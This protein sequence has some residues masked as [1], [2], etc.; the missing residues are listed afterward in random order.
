MFGRD[1]PPVPLPF[2]SPV[3]AMNPSMTRWNFSPVI[4]A[5]LDEGLELGHV[6]RR[7]I[8]AQLDGDAAILGVEIDR[9]VVGGPCHGREPDHGGEGQGQEGGP[10]MEGPMSHEGAVS[11]PLK[12]GDGRDQACVKRAA[13]RSATRGGTKG[14]TSPPMAAIWRTRVAV[15]G[16][17]P[18][19]AGRNTVCTSGAMAPFMPASCIS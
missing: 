1:E 19:E 16:R 18:V 15:I 13:S 3:W 9:V 8:G 4:E 2:G 17:T 10:P 7:E 14:E 5:L 6:L 11:G 12:E